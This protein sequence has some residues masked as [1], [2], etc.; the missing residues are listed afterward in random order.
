VAKI[1]VV[2]DS[3]YFRLKIKEMLVSVGH[4][5]IGEA[6]NGMQATI[7][8]GQLQPDLITMDISMPTMDGIKAVK[9]ILDI[10]PKIKIVMLSAV[11]Q[12]QFVLEALKSGAK[13]F[14]VK[15]VI[16]DVL[17]STIDKVLKEA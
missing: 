2:D 16:K 8:T 3:V 15:P 6:G 4:E 7:L 5:V 17:I 9:K 12:R 14:V 11:G 1:L 10:N 13:H